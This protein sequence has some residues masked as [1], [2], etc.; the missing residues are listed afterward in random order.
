MSFRLSAVPCHFGIP[1]LYDEVYDKM[2]KKR[3]T[4]NSNPIKTLF[5]FHCISDRQNQIPGIIFI[6]HYCQIKCYSK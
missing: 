6:S 3:N 5:H 4:D 2:S 1:I